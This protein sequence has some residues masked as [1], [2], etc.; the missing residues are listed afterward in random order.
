VS[1]S[2]M[3]LGDQVR[4]LVVERQELA[5][6]LRRLGPPRPETME[7]GREIAARIQALK[8]SETAARV[9]VRSHPDHTYDGL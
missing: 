2:L 4:A 8:R 9:A 3:S 5:A 7:R 1:V 6:E